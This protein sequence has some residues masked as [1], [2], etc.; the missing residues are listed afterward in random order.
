[1]CIVGCVRLCVLWLPPSRVASSLLVNVNMPHLIVHDVR[2]FEDV[3]VRLATQP[4]LREALRH[5]LAASVL[6][7]SDGMGVVPSMRASSF[8]HLDVDSASGARLADGRK[9]PAACS[10]RRSPRRLPLFDTPQFVSDLERSMQLM[11]DVYVANA[12]P[13]TGA[14]PPRTI[15][16]DA[17]FEGGRRHLVVGR[18]QSADV[19]HCRPPS[20]RTTVVI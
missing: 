11:W 5:H 6:G 10:E 7:R 1:M 13:P 14:D 18:W 16:T 9:D 2:E 8:R 20:S 4:T 19:C 3:A 17:D 15:L 12:P